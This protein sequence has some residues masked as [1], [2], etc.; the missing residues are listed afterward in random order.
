MLSSERGA[1]AMPTTTLGAAII[2]PLHRA[3]IDSNLGVE[4][5]ASRV[6]LTRGCRPAVIPRKRASAG[7]ACPLRGSEED[8]S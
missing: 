5:A 3:V 6:R 4:S 2:S 1:R 8:G 7:L